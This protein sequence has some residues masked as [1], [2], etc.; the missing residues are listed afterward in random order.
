[1]TERDLAEELAG[2]IERDR[3]EYPF[4][5]EGWTLERWKEAERMHQQGI[6]CEEAR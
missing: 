6:M 5:P 4:L 2:Q 3:A 1:M